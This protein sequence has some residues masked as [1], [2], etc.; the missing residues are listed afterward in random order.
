M[1]KIPQLAHPWY[2]IFC[3]VLISDNEVNGITFESRK[4]GTGSSADSVSDAKM[5]S[6]Q[7]NQFG[8]YNIHPRSDESNQQ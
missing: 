1:L 6:H 7:G 2:Q 8:T 4:S 3:K 5:F